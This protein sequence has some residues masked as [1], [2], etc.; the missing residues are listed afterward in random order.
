[1]DDRALLAFLR[2]D[3]GD[4]GCDQ[5]WEVIHVYVEL[6]VSGGN[7]EAHFPGISAHL[8]SCGPCDVDFRGVLLALLDEVAADEPR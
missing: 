8:A 4:V 3:P 2:T 7:A 5:A 6:V 1:M